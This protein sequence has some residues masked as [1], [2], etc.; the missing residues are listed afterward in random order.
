MLPAACCMLG[1]NHSHR[2]RHVGDQVISHRWSLN[3]NSTTSIET[4]HQPLATEEV[5]GFDFKSSNIASSNIE[6]LRR[7]PNPTPENRNAQFIIHF[8]GKRVPSDEKIC[9]LVDPCQQRWRISVPV[10]TGESCPS[11]SISPKWGY[12]T[13]REEYIGWYRVRADRV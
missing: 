1:I 11:L 8:A 6:S 12:R 9:F 7:V 3:D 13:K 10:M 2:I 4:F 5:R